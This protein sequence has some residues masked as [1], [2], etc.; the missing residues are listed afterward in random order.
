MT[1]QLDKID[2][3][4]LRTLRDDARTPIVALA[5][6]IG[7]SR[8]ATQERLQRL[9]KS[10]AIAGYTIR[11]REREASEVRVWMFL[12][13]SAGIICA[14]IVPKLMRHTEIRLCHSLSGKPDL[15]LLAHL[16]N[17]EAIMPLREAIAQ[18][19]GIADVHTA[20]VLK[21]HFDAW[22]GEV[23]DVFAG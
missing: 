11:F 2:E 16:P 8:S 13:F 1:K 17:H 7:L 10:G 14:D 18:I 6:T 21:A 4:I 19:P 15:T 9:E 20:P 22:T 23:S 12:N 3:N 5:K